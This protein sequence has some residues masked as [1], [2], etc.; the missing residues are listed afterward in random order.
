MFQTNFVEKKKH[1]INI[2]YIY[3]FFFRLLYRLWDKVDNYGTSRQATDINITQ[4]MRFAC[5][6]L[7][8]TDK[9]LE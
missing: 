1:A 6:I 9:Q 2:R 8:A 4:R 7:K 5:W 3:I